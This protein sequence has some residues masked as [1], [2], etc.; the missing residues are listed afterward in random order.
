MSSSRSETTKNRDEAVEEYDVRDLNDSEDDADAPRASQWV[1]EDE[2][3]PSSDPPKAGPSRL[4]ALRSGRFNHSVCI[5][6]VESHEAT[7]LS[8]LPMGVL[9]HAQNVL[10]QAESSSESEDS[11]SDYAQS[12][13]ELNHLERPMITREG[14]Q[15]Q[16]VDIGKRPSK[17]A[18]MEISSKKPVTRRRAV[19]QVKLPVCVNHSGVRSQSLTHVK[20]VRDPRFLPMT[21]KLDADKFQTN[22]NFLTK[23]HESELEILR[24]NLKRARK[25]LSSSPRDSRPERE[26][27]VARLERAMKRA[28]SAVNRDRQVNLERTALS[29]V[30]KEEQEKRRQGKGNWWMKD[31]AKKEALVKARYDALAEKGGQRAVKKAI[32]KRRKKIGQKEKR[33]RPFVKPTGASETGRPHKKR[34]IG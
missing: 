34:R 32:E 28:E 31:S 33:S 18:P 3:F 19:V 21:G 27:E 8:T 10:K 7:D 4:N 15:K 5:T 23:S 29:K 30:K 17:H 14:K 20:E 1:D 16:G 12:E 26:K 24:Q 2:V 13:E 11:E 6:K 25:L 22:Y 9:R